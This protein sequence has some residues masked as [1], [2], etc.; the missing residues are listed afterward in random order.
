MAALPSHLQ[1]IVTANSSVYG[2]PLAK[3]SIRIME[4]LPGFEDED[5][6]CNLVVTTLGH[7]RSFHALS[8]CWG[9]ESADR[10]V[11]AI[12]NS[13]GSRG[14]YTRHLSGYA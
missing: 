9:K 10:A 2:D 7:V 11:S 6:I 12:K 8:Y 1:S 14:T 5:I 13:S 4:L 3:G